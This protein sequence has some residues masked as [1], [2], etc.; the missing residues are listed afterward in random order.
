M[1]PSNNPVKNPKPQL[2]PR[3]EPSLLTV[4]SIAATAG[5][6]A[7][8]RL[9]LKG[10]FKN[11]SAGENEKKATLTQKI[12]DSAKAGAAPVISVMSE[13]NNI[14]LGFTRKDPQFIKI[15]PGYKFK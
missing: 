13:F 6:S 12:F 10:L 11:S 3:I 9:V 14:K 7:L 4:A 15:P 1:N 2:E 5:A 8:A